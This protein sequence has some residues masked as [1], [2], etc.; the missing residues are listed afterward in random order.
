MH[1]SSKLVVA[2]KLVVVM[3]VEVSVAIAATRNSSGRGASFCVR[4]R[5]SAAISVRF[6]MFWFLKFDIFIIIF[7]L[8]IAAFVVTVVGPAGVSKSYAKRA[9]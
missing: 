8:L 3:R 6:L 1:A 2:G 7:I 5:K 4:K 9:A